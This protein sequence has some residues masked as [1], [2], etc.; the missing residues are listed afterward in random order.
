MVVS[1]GDKGTSCQNIDPGDG[2]V[3]DK[4]WLFMMRTMVNDGDN[5]K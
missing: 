3:G 5:G 4:Q 1:N 2:V